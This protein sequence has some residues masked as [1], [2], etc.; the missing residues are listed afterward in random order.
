MNLIDRV[1]LEWSYRTKKGYPDL[2]NEDDLR[3]FESMFGIDLIEVLDKGYRVLKFSE[4]IKRGAPRLVKFYDMVQSNDSFYNT[5][6]SE[7]KL[8]FA[9][10]EYADLFKNRDLD[11]IRKIAGSRV[12]NFPFFIDSENNSVSLNDLL[13]TPEFGGKGA[14]SGT[15]VEDENL[16]IL[17]KKLNSL[18]DVEGGTID[19]VVNGKA[20]KIGSAETQSG[21]PKS[22]FNL[23]DEKGNPVVFISHKKAGSKGPAASDFIRWSGY[24]AYADH[25]EVV[26]FNN[27]LKK[28]LVDNNLEGL[29]NKTRFIAP[30]KDKELIKLLIFGPEYGKPNSKENVNIVIQ[31]E[32]EF[33][34]IG[35]NKYELSGEHVL[36]PPNIPKGEY[37]P[38]L[39]A[40]YRGDR[41]MFGIQ[42][43]EAIAMT[44]AVAYRS[45]NIY[46]LKDGKFEKIK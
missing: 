12:N 18:I 44:K 41:T 36:L 20:Y 3:L 9:S 34:K 22:D 16:Y 40:A 32:V 31:G 26:A 23:L 15:V 10:E 46:L 2:N 35:D 6:G 29:P 1:I 24:T 14:G 43:N 8:K 38:Y 33:E 42:N 19:V 11:G 28:F 7:V 27:G 21:M 4:L 13:K 39:T 25:P 5:D 37:T 45:S 17:K 30:I